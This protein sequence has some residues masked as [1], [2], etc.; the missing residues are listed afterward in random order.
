MLVYVRQKENVEYEFSCLPGA[1][2]Y[3]NGYVR[4]N[5]RDSCTPV[6]LNVGFNETVGL[7]C[8]GSF[9]ISVE[10]EC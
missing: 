3:I 1:S 4:E 9:L 2:T 6:L 8:Y 5:N 7:S 10:E